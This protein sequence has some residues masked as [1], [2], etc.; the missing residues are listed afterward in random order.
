MKSK[1]KIAIIAVF[2]HLGLSV[3]LLTVDTLGIGRYGFGMFLLKIVYQF[4]LLGTLPFLISL[5]QSGKISTI[6]SE[7]TEEPI[8]NAEWVR[9]FLKRL[10]AIVVACAISFFPWL[11]EDSLDNAYAAAYSYFLTILVSFFILL[12]ESIMLYRK[13]MWSKF[14]CNVML[15]YMI[16]SLSIHFL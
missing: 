14:I 5:Y 10:I 16:I 8:K 1:L 13:K 12:I 11:V 2:L 9:H 3:L 4:S 15:L 7:E 6:L